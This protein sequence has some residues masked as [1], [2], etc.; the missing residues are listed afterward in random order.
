MSRL[1]VR[2]QFRQLQIAADPY[3][4]AVYEDPTGSRHGYY[5]SFSIVVNDMPGHKGNPKLYFGDYDE[6]E[7]FLKGIGTYIDY[8]KMIGLYSEEKLEAALE[9][10]KQKDLIETIKSSS[11]SS[12][13][14]AQKIRMSF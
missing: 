8:L 2:D 11:S 7:A 3:G 12:E 4:M 14:K 13:D 5:R 6:C 9:L 1:P 10:V